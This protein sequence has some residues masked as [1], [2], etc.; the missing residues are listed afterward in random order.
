MRRLSVREL[1][2]ALDQ[3]GVDYRHCLE[4]TELEQ[5]L[6]TAASAATRATGPHTVRL[7][8]RSYV[9]PRSSSKCV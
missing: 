3:L 4:R 5:L 1:R 8:R 9:P 2:A 6:D 7:P